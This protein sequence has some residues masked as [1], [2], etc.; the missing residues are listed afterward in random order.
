MRATLA[1]AAAIVE[2]RAAEAWQWQL[3]I[4]RWRYD[5]YFAPAAGGPPY[6]FGTALVG[7]F[8]YAPPWWR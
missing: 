1:A 5:L 4:D 7:S 3:A 2:E 6:P 8:G